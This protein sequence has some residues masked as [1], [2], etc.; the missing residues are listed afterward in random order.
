MGRGNYSIYCR[1]VSDRHMQMGVQLNS[2]FIMI[3]LVELSKLYIDILL[4]FN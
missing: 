3:E 1:Y 2:F 4:F